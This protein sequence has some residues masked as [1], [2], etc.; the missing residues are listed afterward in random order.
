MSFLVILHKKAE[1]ELLESIDWY[2]KRSKIVS[3]KFIVEISNSIDFIQNNPLLPS[4]I[5]G[6]KRKFNLKQFPFS[7]VYSIHKKTIFILAVFHHSRNPKI[8]ES[9]K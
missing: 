1:L 7:I 3:E 2:A 5:Y 9:R 8:W 6:K 4:I